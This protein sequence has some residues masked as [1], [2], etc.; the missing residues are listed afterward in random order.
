[1]KKQHTHLRKLISVKERVVM[2]LA[3]LAIGDGLHM[4]GEVYGVAECMI[5]GIVMEFCKMV[6]LHCKKNLFKFQTKTDL[7]F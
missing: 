6:R 4:V 3:R 7:V 2:S 1:M 5:S